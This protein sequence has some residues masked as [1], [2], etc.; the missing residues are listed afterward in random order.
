MSE[1]KIK[2][3]R[4]DFLAAAGVAAGASALPAKA[5]GAVPR[6]Q[7]DVIV[8]M[9][10]QWSPRFAGYEGAQVNTPNLD[11]MAQEGTIFDSCYTPC[12]VCMPARV[13]LT[14]G[15]YPHNLKIWGN[16][17]YNQDPED[18][19][20]FRDMK[21]AGYYTAQVGKIHRYS[22]TSWKKWAATFKQ[23]TEDSGIDY[24]DKLITPFTIE[25]ASGEYK[26]RLVRLGLF[27][28]YVADMRER[29]LNNPNIVRPAVVE[30]EN[31]PDAY[32]ADRA[33][34]LIRRHPVDKPLFLFVTFPGPHTPLDASGKYET[35][36]PPETLRLLPNVKPFSRDGKNYDAAA[37]QEMYG[38][39]F[40]KIT[41]IDDQIGR[42]I[43]ALKQ[44]GTW[45]N[46]L[47]AF[48]SDHGDMMGSQGRVGKGLFYEESARVPMVI[49]WPGHVAAG[50]RSDAPVQLFD[51]YPAAVEAAG[52]KLSGNHFARSLLPVAAG[53]AASVRDAVFSEIASKKGKSFMCR[54]GDYKWFIADDGEFLFNVKADPYEMQNLINDRSSTAVLA[55]V[56]ERHVKYLRETQVDYTAGV[57]PMVERMR[58]GDL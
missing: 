7:P 30:P 43:E 50:H 2:M 47:A 46:T 44:R 42:I 23:L 25:H 28:K 18:C 15:Q 8:F 17:P 58:A 33:L 16:G 10:D 48:T 29:L 38:S 24:F 20:F 21:A 49:R 6:R 39:Y 31:H 57:P 53:T 5:F 3:S 56:K 26:E 35:M 40:G 19:R 32:T 52:G 34:E 27:D 13:S 11:R 37:V 22:G 45:N 4:R 12:P 36:Y 14:S 1:E 54:L 9:P 55:E 51:V 41:M